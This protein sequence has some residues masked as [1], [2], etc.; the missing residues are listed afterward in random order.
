VDSPLHRDSAGAEY[1]DATQ[2]DSDS[3]LEGCGLG[4]PG[5]TR[6]R[7]QDKGWR[8]EAHS[9]YATRLA[10]LHY[11]AERF[12]RR[13]SEHFVFPAC[14]NGLVDPTRGI[15]SWRTAWR[16]VTRAIQCPACGEIQSLRKIC[17]NVEC[18]AEIG[19]IKNPLVGLRFR[20]LRHSTATKLLEQ[21]TPFAVVAQILG[22]SASTA[23]RMAK[24][25]GHIRPEAQRQALTGVAT[26]E[27][28]VG[29]NQFVHQPSR[30]L[31]CGLRN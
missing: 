16:R 25:Y 26:Q 31:E 5:L 4:E 11:W 21:G 28:Q 9:A 23:V 14:K 3:T 8:R 17:R 27:I 15:A 20:D 24:R 10:T 30:A 12:P 18:R 6:G 22:W 2:G 19:G 29:V 7:K 13:R 1:G